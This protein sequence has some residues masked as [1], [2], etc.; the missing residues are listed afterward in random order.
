MGNPFG[1]KP[2]PEFKRLLSMRPGDVAEIAHGDRFCVQQ[3][4]AKNSCS[5]TKMVW[6]A[7]RRLSDR[8][9][10]ARHVREGLVVVRC[11]PQ[12]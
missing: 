11:L 9:Y 4:R 8:V 7:N 10:K 12:G 2:S 5:I 1:S 6:R 3:G